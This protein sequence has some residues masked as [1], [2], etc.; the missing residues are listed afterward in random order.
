MT[1][2]LTFKNKNETSNQEFNNMLEKIKKDALLAP[3][4]KPLTESDL[5][6]G[7]LYQRSGC[8]YFVEISFISKEFVIVER[9]ADEM[10]WKIKDF[11]K[12]FESLTH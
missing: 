6:I 9:E 1:N 10:S 12:R 4:P 3:T 5:E 2:L 11:I 8:S 7:T